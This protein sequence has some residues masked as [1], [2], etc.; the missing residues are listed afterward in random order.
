MGIGVNNPLTYLHIQSGS[1]TNDGDG[2][3]S[4]TQTGTEA[5]LIDITSGFTVGETYAS[6]AWMNGSRRR[7]MISPVAESTD[8]D[9]VGLSFYTQG[10]DGPGD[11]FES[12]RIARSG[13]VGIG[14]T[15]SW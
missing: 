6:I 9:Y 14:T 4:M 10:T 12:M 15:R 1:A 7:A 8:G 5:M 2:S 13:N 11:F 3:A